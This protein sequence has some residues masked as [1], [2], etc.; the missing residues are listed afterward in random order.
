MK[1]RKWDK[2][3]VMVGKPKDKWQVSEVL[4]VFK[5]EGKVIVKGVNVVKRHIKK[6]GTTAG[7]IIEMEKAVDASNVM[8]MCPITEKPTKLGLLI[9]DEK[10]KRKK[11]RYSKAAVK[12][13]KAPK[14]AIIK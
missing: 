1:I 9:T 4:K 11:A 14:D 12:S 10:G 3:K 8:V 13:G 7:Q 5:D 2:V 6:S